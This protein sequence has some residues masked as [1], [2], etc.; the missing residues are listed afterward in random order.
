MRIKGFYQVFRDDGTWTVAEWNGL[1]WR[2][3]GDSH[4]FG[5]THW[6][7]IGSQVLVGEE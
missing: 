3:C 7:R 1:A 2:V 4:Y 6:A 5:D